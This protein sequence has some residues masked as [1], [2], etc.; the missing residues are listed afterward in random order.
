[1]RAMKI[2]SVWEAINEQNK[3]L[4]EQSKKFDLVIKESREDTDRKIALWT[5]EHRE[6]RREM[7][8]RIAADRKETSERLERDRVA[9]EARL[10]A[11]RKEATD[12]LDRERKEVQERFEKEREESLKEFKTQRRWLVANFVAVMIAVFGIFSAI[13]TAFAIFFLQN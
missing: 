9:T 4:D 8:A 3:K 12:K 6:E 10:A 5:Q 13:G 7:E 1:M 2:G 11:D